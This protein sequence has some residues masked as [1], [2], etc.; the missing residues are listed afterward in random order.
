MLTTG[1]AALAAASGGAV[2]TAP[3]VDRQFTVQTPDRLRQVASNSR[4]EVEET[5]KDIRPD[6]ISQQQGIFY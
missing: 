3:S 1:A 2:R 5:E 6:K 4:A